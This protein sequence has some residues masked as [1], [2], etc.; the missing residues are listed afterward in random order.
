VFPEIPL[1][2]APGVT[3]G[4]DAMSVKSGFAGISTCKSSGF[5]GVS[6]VDVDDGHGGA[7]GLAGGT[8][9]PGETS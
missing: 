2:M 1:G 5:N 6:V 8:V 9:V 3:K 7:G 4:W